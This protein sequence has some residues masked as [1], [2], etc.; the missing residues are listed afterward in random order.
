MKYHIFQTQHS[1]ILYWQSKTIVGFEF[2]DITDKS[3]TISVL[4]SRIVDSN[5]EIGKTE[6]FY[7]KETI[8]DVTLL[9]A[10][11]KLS[12]VKD[13][14]MFFDSEKAE[15]LMNECENIEIF[16]INE[17]NTDLDKEIFLRDFQWFLYLK[18]V[19]SYDLKGKS[20]L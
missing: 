5:E 19:G 10:R 1:T 9:N 13:L 17:F 8:S 16:T 20:I 6:R 4:Q 2:A 15:I 12:N 3:V 18:L 7:Q 11:D 14:T